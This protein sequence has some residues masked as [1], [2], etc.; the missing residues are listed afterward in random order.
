MVFEIC[1]AVCINAFF[2]LNSD[3]LHW[4]LVKY[5]ES[6]ISIYPKITETV[7]FGD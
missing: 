1:S 5:V 7:P 6:M 3:N 2:Y 4:N